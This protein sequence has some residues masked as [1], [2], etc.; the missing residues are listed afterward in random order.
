MWHLLSN[1]KLKVRII[2]EVQKITNINQKTTNSVKTNSL[3]SNNAQ[4]ST[5]MDETKS[6]DSIFESAAKK[7]N[8]SVDLLKAVGKAESSFNAK[9]VSRV[10]AQGI[11]QLMPATAK[12]LG[13]KDSFNA[14][15]NIMGGAKYLS[16]LSKKYDGDVKLTLAAYNAGSGN[17]AKYGGIPPFEETQ[18]YVVKVMKYMDEGVSTGNA[19]VRVASVA[20]SITS[21]ITPS[22][23]TIVTSEPNASED[24]SE[25][26]QV[27]DSIFTQE[28]YKKF[29]EKYLLG[30]DEKKNEEDEDPNYIA[31]KSLSYNIAVM[32][33][34]NS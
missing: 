1:F 34:L 30:D 3:N 4:F 15:E 27:M 10:G 17:V 33:L 31:L 18:K 7:Y 25:L 9:A 11:M 16:Q 28:D 14:E 8:V 20:P 23:S 32:N 21:S 12:E 6:L 19:N 2:L 26:S 13:V 22:N 29:L 24:S 5:Y